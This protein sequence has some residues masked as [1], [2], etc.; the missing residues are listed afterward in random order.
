MEGR[1]TLAAGEALHAKNG[2]E[3]CA[4]AGA[5]GGRG[6]ADRP[7]GEGGDVGEVVRDARKEGDAKDG[8]EERVAGEDVRDS[9]NKKEVAGVGEGGWPRNRAWCMGVGGDGRPRRPD[10]VAKKVNDCCS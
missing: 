2:G 3:K 1:T 4:R 5:R 7:L 9:R 8:R 10:H 6:D